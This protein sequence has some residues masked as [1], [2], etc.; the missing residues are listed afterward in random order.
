[1]DLSFGQFARE[2]AVA[3]MPTDLAVLIVG[4]VAR[5]AASPTARLQARILP[6][7]AADRLLAPDDGAFNGHAAR[8]LA[9]WQEE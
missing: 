4:V 8:L 2:G 3:A 6:E 7:G 5:Q 9:F 1:M